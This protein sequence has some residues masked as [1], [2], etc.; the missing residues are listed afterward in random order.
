MYPVTDVIQFI[1]CTINERVVNGY[2]KRRL[3]RMTN[4]YS[5]KIRGRQSILHKKTTTKKKTKIM[6]HSKTNPIR[7]EY[8][9]YH[10]IDN[11]QITHVQH[12]V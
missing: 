4:Y 12:F 11:E 1:H 5:H 8:S 10:S 7:H 6:V 3:S 9:I 2:A